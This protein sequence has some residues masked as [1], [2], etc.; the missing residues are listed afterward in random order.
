MTVGVG[1][2]SSTRVRT[3]VYL[4]DA[5]MG[6]FETILARFGLSPMYLK[7]HWSNIEDGLVTWITEGSLKSVQLE[8]GDPD[9]PHAVFQVP[10]DY[11]TTGDGD[12]AFV[13]SQA[14]ITRAMAKFSTIPRGVDYRIVVEHHGS[15]T[16]VDGWTST[17]TADTSNLAK[18]SLGSVASGPDARA[19]LNYFGR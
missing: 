11:T 3:A 6:T 18:Y 14:R 15:H 10:L 7:M 13:T 1:T 2:H 9:N 8:C 4:T 17:T 12:I 16:P 19:T 5:I